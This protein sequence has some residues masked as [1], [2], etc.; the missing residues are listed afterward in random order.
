MEH[1][2]IIKHA[3]RHQQ[4]MVFDLLGPMSREDSLE[5]ITDTLPLL[6]LQLRAFQEN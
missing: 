1:D 2:G 3:D 4:M 6:V 5:V